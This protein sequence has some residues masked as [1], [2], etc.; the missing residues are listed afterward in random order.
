MG[1]DVEKRMGGVVAVLNVAF[2]QQLGVWAWQHPRRPDQ[3]HEGDLDLRQ[4]Q[5]GRRDLAFTLE[6]QVAD[7]AGGKIQRQLRA[8]PQR[9]LVRSG[10]QVHAP[11]SAVVQAEQTHQ[12]KKFESVRLGPCLVNQTRG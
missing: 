8:E 1:K 3:A 2:Q 9:V 11:G 12:L 10:G 5:A 6:M 7:L 4:R